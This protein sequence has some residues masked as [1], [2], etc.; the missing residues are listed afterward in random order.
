MNSTS[1]TTSKRIFNWIKLLEALPYSH[2]AYDWANQYFHPHYNA[3]FIPS[4]IQTLIIGSE[5]DHVTPLLLFSGNSSWHKKNIL[6]DW[7]IKF[8]LYG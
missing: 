1:R 2:A 8:A 7:E 5:H 6:Q 3:S 4:E